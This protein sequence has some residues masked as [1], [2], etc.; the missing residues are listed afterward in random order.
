[1]D[2]GLPV[3]MASTRLSGPLR[4]S[5]PS[6]HEES[7]PTRKAGSRCYTSILLEFPIFL[8]GLLHLLAATFG[9]IILQVRRC[10]S[11]SPQNPMD[12]IQIHIFRAPGIL[13][14]QRK[15]RLSYSLWAV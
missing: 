13:L 1:M 7:G 4:A 6:S 3:T 10:I 15:R 8:Y 11:Q 14:F 12:I 2:F 5:P 9:I